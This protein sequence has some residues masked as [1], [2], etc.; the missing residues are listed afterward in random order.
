M[1]TE[2]LAKWRCR[3][4]ELWSYSPSGTRAQEFQEVTNFLLS[5]TENWTNV[6]SPQEMCSLCELFE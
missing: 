6:G 3:Y 4:K 2:A 5:N 1:V